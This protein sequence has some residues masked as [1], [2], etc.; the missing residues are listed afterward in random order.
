MA[1]KTNASV[2]NFNLGMTNRDFE[3]IV[4][5][6]AKEIDRINM[7]VVD[8]SYVKA[9]VKSITGIT[10]W[11]FSLDFND[12][13]FLTGE[14]RIHSDNEQ[15]D[16]PHS[17]AE[18]IKQAIISFPSTHVA[19]NSLPFDSK[20]SDYHKLLINFVK[21]RKELEQKDEQVKI[22]RRKYIKAVASIPIIIAALLIIF[23]GVFE[24]HRKAKPEIA[25]SFDSSEAK[26]IMLA[27][28]VNMF[29]NTGFTN[30]ELRADKVLPSNE[31]YDEGKVYSITID[32]KANFKA[33]DKFNSD[34]RIIITYSALKEIP[35][36][37]SAE[38]VVGKSKDEVVASLNDAGFLNIL[39]FP[40]P[41]QW[42]FP[43]DTVI[44]IFQLNS[45]N[46]IE[47][48]VLVRPDVPL[49]IFYNS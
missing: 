9:T 8:G 6:V 24:T 46:K 30:I 42:A 22:Y 20:E 28:A 11:N 4:T 36:P 29:K 37:F 31:N 45:S 40:L 49:I 1:H 38:E 35:F 26:D 3:T 15:S 21:S 39:A 10:F 16:I 44:N 14:Y 19:E 23:M 18:L 32:G 13:G 43:T 33:G 48:G 47:K 2:C 12:N 17:F 34:A 27:D 5:S 41:N 25:M 7:V